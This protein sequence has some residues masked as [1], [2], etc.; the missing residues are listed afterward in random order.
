MLFRSAH[1]RLWATHAEAGRSDVGGHVLHL[2]AISDGGD[3]AGFRDA[4]HAKKN[5]A[6]LPAMSEDFSTDAKKRQGLR[7]RA[8]NPRSTTMF[9]TRT[10]LFGDSG[11]SCQPHA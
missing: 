1:S 9:T 6:P 11:G 5:S 7:S 2:V 10:F 8:D 4:V 3:G